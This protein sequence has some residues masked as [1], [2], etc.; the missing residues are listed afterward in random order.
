MGVTEAEGRRRGGGS[1]MVYVVKCPKL[2]EK[3]FHP[4]AYT[5]GLLGPQGRKVQISCSSIAPINRKARSTPPCPG[6]PHARPATFY[7]SRPLGPKPALLCPPTELLRS[8]NS[9]F[10]YLIAATDGTLGRASLFLPLMQLPPSRATLPKP[11]CPLPAPGPNLIHLIP[12]ANYPG[13]F[14]YRTWAG[15]MYHSL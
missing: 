15:P 5:R 9:P 10:C 11:K 3:P 1:G 13:S 4:V 2:I 12:V 14:E 8:I 6:G 7:R